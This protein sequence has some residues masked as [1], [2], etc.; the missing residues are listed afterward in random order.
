MKT[1]AS[2]PYSVTE[3]T[4]VYI[5]GGETTANARGLR[6]ESYDN[7]LKIYGIEWSGE[8]TS[9]ESINWDVETNAVLY[10]MSGQRI[11]RPSKGIYIKNGKKVII[12]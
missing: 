9:I 3:P 10:N 2:I 4:Y 7:A 8:V 11:E 5:Y 1:G 6:A 12:K